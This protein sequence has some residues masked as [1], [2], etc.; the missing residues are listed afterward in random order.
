MQV[1]LDITKLKK[2]LKK[3]KFYRF[4]QDYV[5]F[6]SMRIELSEIVA[7]KRKLPLDKA[8]RIRVLTIVE[9]ESFIR[10]HDLQSYFKDTSKE[11]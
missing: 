2:Y 11:D 7:E 6:E 10:T 9:I 8:K 1:G 3:E 4:F 5:P